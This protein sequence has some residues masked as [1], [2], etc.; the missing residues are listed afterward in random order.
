MPHP[1][2]IIFLDARREFRF[3]LRANGEIITSGESY[4]TRT[5]V[6]RA[7]AAVRAYAPA[8]RTVDITRPARVAR[9]R[10]RNILPPAVLLSLVARRAERGLE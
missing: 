5:G 1:R 6:E 9:A 2:F 4:K 7:I 8:A 10:A 3:R